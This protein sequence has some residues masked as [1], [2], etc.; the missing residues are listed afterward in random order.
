MHKSKCQSSSVTL[1][2]YI[3]SVLCKVDETLA[4]MVYTSQYLS[5]VLD[6]GLPLH[7]HVDH[8]VTTLETGQGQCCVPV[9]LDLQ[10]DIRSSSICIQTTLH[11]THSAILLFNSLHTMHLLYIYIGTCSV[12]A[13]CEAIRFL[14]Q[15]WIMF[16]AIFR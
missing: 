16:P 5:S 11:Y 2:F 10:G 12:M 1:T 13:N 7:Q 9:G 14:E 3:Q 6:I 15:H 8:L 4:V